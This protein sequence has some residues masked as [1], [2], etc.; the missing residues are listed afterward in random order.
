M[1]AGKMPDAPG[2]CKD[3]G[4]FF[5]YMLKGGRGEMQTG[6]DGH[7]TYRRLLRFVASPVLMMVFTSLYGVVDGFF[8]SNYV[9][10]TGLAAVNLIWPVIMGVGTIGFMV[11]AGGSAEVSKTMGEG[12]FRKANESFSLLIYVTA[13]AGIALSLLVFSLIRPISAALGAEGALLADCISYGRI[14]TLF[15]LPFILQ[16]AFQSFLVTAGK[17]DLSLR[18]SLFGGVTNMVLDYVFIVPMHMGVAGAA[19]ATGLGEAVGGVLPLLYFLKKNDSLLALGRTRWDGRMLA[20]TCVNGVSEMVTNL[21]ATVVETLYNIR[22]MGLVGEGGV[23]A[24]GIIMYVSF[25]FAALFYGYAMGSAPLVGFHY[26]A[27]DRQ[28]LKS[29]FRKSLTLL[30]AAGA[31]LVLLAELVSGPLVAVFA[32]YDPELLAL[33]LRGFRLYSMAYLI[34]GIT[35]WGSSFFTA[36]SNGLVS[37]VISFLRTLVFETGAVLLLPLVL[38]ID[39]VWLSVVAAEAAALA[40][41]VFF[42]RRLG[43]RYGYLGKAA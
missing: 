40:V 22:L 27:E 15:A 38:G 43:P 10:R 34:M 37:A 29:L 13:G 12:D 11:G 14:L 7:F 36:L 41:T 39:G 33:T 1:R 32:G 16:V 3:L 19:L 20:R 24:Y 28:E 6:L 2:V 35:A 17:P 5:S 23:A 26:G 30:M 21:S 31:F 8:V 18:F 25:V 9:G 4:V 42:F